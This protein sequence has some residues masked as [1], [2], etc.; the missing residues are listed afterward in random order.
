MEPAV[1]PHLRLRLV[2]DLLLLA[3]KLLRNLVQ[4]LQFEPS[5]IRLRQ[6]VLANNRHGFL[7]QISEMSM[8]LV[9]V[10]HFPSIHFQFVASPHLICLGRQEYPE[11]SAEWRSNI[12]SNF[13][14]LEEFGI[15]RVEVAALV[16]SE[17]EFTAVVEAIEWLPEELLGDAVVV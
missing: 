9:W 16:G 1:H 12:E 8:R 7:H 11:E 14:H 10:R 5:L 3:E 17:I 13:H 4:V 6:P 15:E 2:P